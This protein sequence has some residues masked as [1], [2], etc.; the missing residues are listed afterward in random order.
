MSSPDASQSSSSTV[1]SI[2][3]KR[4]ADACCTTPKIILGPAL[5]LNE[6][7]T[8]SLYHYTCCANCDTLIDIL[9]SV[10]PLQPTCPKPSVSLSSQTP[11]IASIVEPPPTNPKRSPLPRN[12]PPPI[13]FTDPFTTSKP[14]PPLPKYPMQP[15]EGP[16]RTISE[17]QHRVAPYPSPK[18]PLRGHNPPLLPKIT[19]PGLYDA[20]HRALRRVSGATFAG[21]L[22]TIS[23]RSMTR[24]LLSYP[25]P[26]QHSTKPNQVYQSSYPPPP[27]PSYPKHSIT[28][29]PR[30][31]TVLPALTPPEGYPQHIHPFRYQMQ[32][33]SNADSL[34]PRTRRLPL[35]QQQRQPSHEQ[36]QQQRIQQH[37]QH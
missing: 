5:T 12:K 26:E 2:R 20:P 15:K 18:P 19:T 32:Y 3:A 23:S 1:S 16:A 35:Q 27:W 11:V 6:S 36:E 14:P 30:Y 31:Y 17:H 21:S 28:R 13:I 33:T 8:G 7:E 24:G 34:S 22:P 25:H 10:K 37:Q 9:V 29:L 4:D